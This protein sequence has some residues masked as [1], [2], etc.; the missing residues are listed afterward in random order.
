MVVIDAWH[1]VLG[2]PETAT[3][4]EI[5][6]SFRRLAK[7]MHPDRDRSPGATERFRRLL[8]AYQEAK[9]LRENPT[10]T[11]QL[12]P[13]VK[14][15]KGSHDWHG[16]DLIMRLSVPI[17]E[18]ISCVT[19]TV[20]ITRKG[21]CKTCAGTG[22]QSKKAKK[23]VFCNGTGLQGMA[24][25]LKQKKKC[26]YCAGVG[27]IPE[28]PKCPDCGAAGIVQETVQHRIQLNP[29]AE[30]FTIEGAGNLS[31]P[32]SQPGNLIIEIGVKNPTRYRLSGLD[33]LGP[34]DLSPAQAILGCT[35]TLSPFGQEVTIKVPSGSQNG[36]TI[37]QE[38]AGI[39]Y[40]GHT[41]T[42]RGRINVIIPQVTTT[43]ERDLYAQLVE[44][45]K[46]QS[47]IS[48]LAV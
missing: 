27:R 24:L 42:F 4:R 5:L 2:V 37:E 29:Y 40:K 33:V 45:E 46:I 3:D 18:I 25:V 6:A 17:A 19:K 28:P 43:K 14:T 7:T 36:Q 8:D 11:P 12:R 31:S 10:P 30:V 15:S 38:H 21:L 41:G 39:E 23:C 34:I 26:P 16:T 44:L 35:V 9:K 47:G 32:G 22:S 1:I 48:D 20:E 13:A